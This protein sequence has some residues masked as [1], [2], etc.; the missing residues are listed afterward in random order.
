MTRRYSFL[1]CKLSVEST[2]FVIHFM[3]VVRVRVHG[4]IGIAKGVPSAWHGD[5]RP[6]RS[7]LLASVGISSGRRVELVHVLAWP[8]RLSL[9]AGLCINL[10]KSLAS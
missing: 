3:L 2:L 6:G 10:A 1:I 7:G 5:I 4:S 8:Y 9:Y